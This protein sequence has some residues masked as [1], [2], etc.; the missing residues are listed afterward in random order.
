VAD[1]TGFPLIFRSDIPV[2]YTAAI[3]VNPVKFIVA[4]RK[5]KS[6][7]KTV[8]RPFGLQLWIALGVSMVLLGIILPKLI[9]Y[10]QNIKKTRNFWTIQRAMLFLIASCSM[11]GTNLSDTTGCSS[12]LS[13]G[14][15]LFSTSVLGFGYAGT[16]ISF[17]TTP[18]YEPAPKTIN[19][20]ATAVKLGEYF[21]GTFSR[22][23]ISS[24][25]KGKKS[26]DTEILIDYM[27]RNPDKLTR[28]ASV[29]ASKMKNERYAFISPEI[30][31]RGRIM[32]LFQ[33]KLSLSVDNF[34]TILSGYLLRKDF[35]YKRTTKKIITRLFEVGI[36]QRIIRKE[37]YSQHEDK[38]KVHPLK[39]EEL[40]GSFVVLVIGY[41][42]SF[43]SFIGELITG[44][45]AKSKRF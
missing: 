36:V 6:D 21:C 18:C 17:L 33:G 4:E 5:L 44:Y 24:Y 3:V 20:L 28:Y 1:I 22:S 15:C 25:L 30:F 31:S 39:L 34:K 45:Y 43:L 10:G 38:D 19:E 37:C 2:D 11:Q 14:V 35:P 23:A 12:R 16:L 9:N 27:E 7:W 26:T 13:I 8:I 41:I 29:I 40:A 42:L 32:P